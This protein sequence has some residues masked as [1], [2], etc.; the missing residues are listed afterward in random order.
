MLHSRRYLYDLLDK[1]QAE[2]NETYEQ[3]LEN[4]FDYFLDTEF[5]ERDLDYDIDEARADFKNSGDFLTVE[6]FE[7]RKMDN[8]NSLKFKA[9]E[10]L[11][12]EID[13]LNIE[14]LR[15]LKEI[16]YRIV[17]IVDYISYQYFPF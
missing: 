4:C 8:L 3:A 13:R 14:E 5:H 12:K 11:I 17:K 1:A 7:E 9:E 6:D 2:A 15:E 10:E 16:Y